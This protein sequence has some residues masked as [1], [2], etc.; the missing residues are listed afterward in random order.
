MNAMEMNPPPL[1]SPPL[2]IVGMPRSGTTLLAT[3]L[4]S[5]PRI[6]ISPETHFIN[7][8]V[9]DLQRDGVDPDDTEAVWERWTRFHR[10]AMIDVDP[11][12]LR[13]RWLVRAA[14]QDPLKSLLASIIELHA[15]NR[16]KVRGGEKTPDHFQHIDTL[17][18]WFPGAQVIFIIR[19]PR[20]I[21]A[22]LLRVPWGG[23]YVDQHA[24]KWMKSM[25]VVDRYQSDPRFSV[26][27]YEDLVQTPEATIRQLCERIGEDPVPQMLATKKETSVAGSVIA[28]WAS[29]HFAQS[30]RPPQTGSLEKWVDQLSRAQ[31]SMIES[32]TAATMK[33]WG[34]EPRIGRLTAA[35]KWQQ[36]RYHWIR[37]FKAA[38]RPV[39]GSKPPAA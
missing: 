10:F 36:K 15:A 21:S 17:L 5:H 29:D 20:A 26:L 25:A 6:D 18:S 37:F 8:F 32:I 1:T 22:S 11:E 28:D 27:R 19:D 7:G 13:E 38:L 24:E 30:A 2:F 31:V 12:R 4:G 16:G 39:S 23:K 9:R 3:I 35:G 34:Y 33:Q 14:T